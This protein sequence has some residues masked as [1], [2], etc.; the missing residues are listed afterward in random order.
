MKS[1]V[2]RILVAMLLLSSLVVVADEAAEREAVAAANAWLALIDQG[3]YQKSWS[4]SSSLFRGAIT[5]DDWA[6]TARGVRVPLGK[7]VSREVKSKH[8]M[9]S[10]PGAPD[11]KYV[12]IQFET[13]YEKKKSAVETVTPML[14]QDGKWR[15]S[16]YFI[17]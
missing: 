16:G 9:E 8:Y 10:L 15:V 3:E 5:A 13:S 2:V 7:L 1:N 17:K 4:E 6:R 11:G 12:V 14:D